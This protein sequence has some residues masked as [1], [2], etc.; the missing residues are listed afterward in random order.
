MQCWELRAESRP[1][2]A[3]LVIR[4]ST[5]LT[6]VAEYMDLMGST[7][8]L[9]NVNNSMECLLSDNEQASDQP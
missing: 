7:M 4:L 8:A 2:F 6:A 9:R 1:S 3:E 5:L